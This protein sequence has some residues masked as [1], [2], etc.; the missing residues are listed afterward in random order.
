MN[1]SDPKR[2]SFPGSISKNKDVLCGG[3]GLVGFKGSLWICND[4]FGNSNYC[5]V[6]L[7]VSFFLIL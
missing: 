1:V 7:F 4:C 5:D 3:C 6:P 2:Y